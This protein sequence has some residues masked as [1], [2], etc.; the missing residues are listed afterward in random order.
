MPVTPERADPEAAPGEAPCPPMISAPCSSPGGGR[1][2]GQRT[3]SQD[4]E[5]DGREESPRTLP[6]CPAA[7]GLTTGNDIIATNFYFFLLRTQAFKHAS[8]TE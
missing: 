1:A 5:E 4:S 7:A 8:Q 3:R 2:R 6:P